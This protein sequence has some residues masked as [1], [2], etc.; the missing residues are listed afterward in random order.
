MIAARS[1]IFAAG[2]ER[3]ANC[4]RIL[5]EHLVLSVVIRVTRNLFR[6]SGCCP[7]DK[8]NRLLILNLAYGTLVE[9]LWHRRAIFRLLGRTYLVIEQ[10]WGR[11]ARA[12]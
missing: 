5:S 1:L 12:S 6:F 7:G 11:A 4:S 10:F 3:I 8:H 9:L 2:L